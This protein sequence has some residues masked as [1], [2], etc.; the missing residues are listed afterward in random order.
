MGYRADKEK[1]EKNRDAANKRWDAEK[2]FTPP[3][4]EEVREYCYEKQIAI[5]P[6]LFWDYYNAGGW[7]AA[8]GNPIKNW[9]SQIKVW[10]AREQDI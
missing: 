2:T 8:N 6:D 1:V 4:L 10:E 3:T 5:D 9:K 7:I